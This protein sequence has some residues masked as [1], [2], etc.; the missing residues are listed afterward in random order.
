MNNF[1]LIITFFSLL[2]P[3]STFIVLDLKMRPVS[4]VMF[5]KVGW[6]GTQLISDSWNP[7]TEKK[8]K[9]TLTGTFPQDISEPD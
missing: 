1:I 6:E 5:N 7:Q 4:S 9:Q 8:K 3:S 2:V